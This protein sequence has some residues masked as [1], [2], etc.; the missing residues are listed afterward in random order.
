MK[1]YTVLTGDFV[2]ST[3]LS[4][5]DLASAMHSLDA[6]TL[7]MS[8]WGETKLAG[9]AKDGGFARRGGDGWQIILENTRLWLRAVLYIQATL[10][11]ASPNHATR[12]AIAESNDSLSPDAWKDPNI[13]HGPAFTAS[14]R[15]L[16]EMGRSTRIAHASG[17]VRAATVRLADE[18]TRRWT[19]A[20]AR[21]L[22]EALLPNVGSRQDIATKFGIS[23]EA[24]NQSLWSSGYLAL[25]EAID[26]VEQSVD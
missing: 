22:C 18:I 12:I 17:G 16:E 6:A 3:K 7:E 23:R 10:R 19:Q 2:D 13:G 14:G 9:F 21:V 25:Q 4:E 5:D 15:L 20:Q 11:A 1:G 8:G 26:F 24:V